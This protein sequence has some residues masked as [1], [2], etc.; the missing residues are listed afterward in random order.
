MFVKQNLRWLMAAGL[1]GG[2][3]EMVWVGLYGSI[4]GTEIAAV[5][6]SITATFFASS[7][8]LAAAPYIGVMIHLLLSV[9]L[10]IG[11]G[12]IVWPLIRS[13][14]GAYGTL[15]S[16][17]MVLALVWKVNFY[18]LLPVVNPEFVSL[19]PLSVSLVS[20][21]LFGLLMGVTLIFMPKPGNNPL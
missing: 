9:L 5:A 21:T 8:S 15:L 4:S 1:A 19:L 6:S 20:K 14:F 10:A 16:S 17:V 2:L 13:R 7:V 3:A 11:F 18:V 12:F